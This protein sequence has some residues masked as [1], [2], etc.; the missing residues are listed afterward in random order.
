MAVGVGVGCRGLAEEVWAG[1]EPGSRGRW[2][3]ERRGGT[4]AALEVVAPA[5]LGPSRPRSGARR[6]GVLQALWG[7][8]LAVFI[9]ATPQVEVQELST[10]TLE[11][12]LCIN[13]R[14]LNTLV[15]L[16]CHDLFVFFR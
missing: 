2:R 16:Y 8:D 9:L 1:Q 3:G 6:P 10:M 7:P 14:Y 4:G 12:S 5:C 13:T 11:R 15:Y